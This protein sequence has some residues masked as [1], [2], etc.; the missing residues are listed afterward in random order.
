MAA[1]GAAALLAAASPPAATAQ[2]VE[3]L[4]R[5]YGTPLPPGYFETVDLDRNA[6]R[7]RRGF[8]RAPGGEP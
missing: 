4:A 6:F 8:R 3:M 5:H 1:L 7:F 2:D